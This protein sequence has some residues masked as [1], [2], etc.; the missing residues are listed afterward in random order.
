[1][2]W[3]KPI[4]ENAIAMAYVPIGSVVWDPCAG[5][6]SSLLAA[7]QH[8]RIWRG[9]EQQPKWCDLIRRRWTRWADEHHIQAGKG[10]LRQVV[11]FKGHAVRSAMR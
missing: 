8:G 7:A 2:S 6:G 10:A 1:M 4:I 11:D 5:S 9:V 3:G